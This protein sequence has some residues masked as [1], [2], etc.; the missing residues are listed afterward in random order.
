MAQRHSFIRQITAPAVLSSVAALRHWAVDGGRAAGASPGAL[1]AI[2]LAATEVVTNAVVH[3]LSE[4]WGYRHDVAGG[5]VVGS[6][7]PRINVPD[8]PES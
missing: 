2:E 8:S 1:A 3:A 5:R 4:R 7:S 6:P